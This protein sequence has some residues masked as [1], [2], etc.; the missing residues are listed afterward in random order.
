MK[1]MILAA[2]LGTRM[3]P[4]TDH[5]PKPLLKVADKPLIQYHIE[6][7]VNAGITELVIN[8]AYLGE[9]IEAYLGDG[10]RFG[11]SIQYSHEPEP[12]ET[13][14][15]LR[16][17]SK[18]LSNQATTDQPFIVING[19]VWTDYPFENLLDSLTGDQLAYTVLVDSP[20]QHPDGDFYLLADNR[21]ASE[22]GSEQKAQKFTFSGIS[23]LSPALLSL[24]Q[25][26]QCLGPLLRQ[27]M[28]LGKVKGEH[29]QGQWFDIGTPERLYELDESLTQV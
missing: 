5:T 12:L 8:L 15:G 13:A 11:A 3:R 18:L 24:D 26:E 22:R 4:L 25:S 20:P 16:F 28:N 17:A 7:L 10:A 29:Y 9:Q 23:V 19:D 21:V 2:G 1:A 14:G 6:R 27:A